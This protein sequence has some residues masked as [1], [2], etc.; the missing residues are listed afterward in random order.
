MNPNFP[1]L[2]YNGILLCLSFQL[3]AIGLIKCFSKSR[4]DIILGILC[5]FIGSAFFYNLYWP[6]FSSNLFYN[7]LMGGYKGLF[8]APLI[9][10]YIALTQKSLQA[11]RHIKAHLALPAVFSFAYLFIKFGFRDFYLS[12][13][14]D[15][16]LFMSLALSLISV[17]YLFRGI[18]LF[19]KLKPLLKKSI[20]KRYQFFYF[21]LIS[22]F[23]FT[24]INS[25][26]SMIFYTGIDQELWLFISRY[27][28]MPLGMLSS[29]GLI[30]FSFI[31][32]DRLKNFSFGKKIYSGYHL[33]QDNEDIKAFIQQFF[34]ENKIFKNPDF[35]IQQALKN[36]GLEE[37]RLR[38]FVKK[39]YD[40]TLGDFINEHRINEFKRMLLAGESS[41][42]NLTGIAKQAGFN[43]RSTFYRHFK[44]KEGITPREYLDRVLKTANN[45]DY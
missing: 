24:N 15:L 40:Q 21:G 18:Q 4:R 12:N 37:K 33:I 16:V 10:L 6:K 9:Y 14:P 2:V 45:K 19:Q 27:I 43:S 23:V 11:T 3:L 34:I 29:I 13:K 42:Y 25:L 35:N 1:D 20:F 28:F 30:L 7:V 22:Y 39:E 38:L 8:Y 36:E 31:E 41:K 5:L 17:F 26:V 32:Y 44:N